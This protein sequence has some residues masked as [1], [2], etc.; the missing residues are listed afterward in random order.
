MHCVTLNSYATIGIH[1]DPDDY[2]TLLPSLGSVISGMNL[3]QLMVQPASITV[4]LVNDN[5]TEGNEQ[6]TLN[7]ESPSFQIDRN[8]VVRRPN[9]S[10][11]IIQDDDGKRN[12]S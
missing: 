6:F 9:I 7:L 3:D 4:M 1:A 12:I 8:R 5:V 2:T 11:I 10:L